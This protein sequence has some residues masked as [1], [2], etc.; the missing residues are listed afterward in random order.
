MA[1]VIVTGSEGFLGRNLVPKLAELGHRVIAID[2]IMHHGPHLA[3]VT[4][5]YFD[6][7][8]ASSLLPAMD[9][10]G[11]SVLIHLAWGLSRFKGFEGQAAQVRL[12]ACL[13]DFA[14]EKRF[15]KVVLMGSA[16]EF[17]RCSG[18]ISEA[19]APELP[20]SP[21]GWAKR[22]ARDLL[23]SWSA[24]SEIPAMIMR[25]FIMYGP[26]QR[27]DL[28]LPSAIE[29]AR[30]KKPT[31]FTD[32]QQVRDFVYVDD[33]SRAILAGLNKD[34][35][36][37]HEFNLGHGGV[38]VVDTLNMISRHFDAEEFIQVGARPRRPGEPDTQIADCARAKCQL[39][40]SAD[41]D[42]REGLKRCF[43]LFS[44]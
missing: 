13:L 29:A 32:G 41:I 5:E 38:K 37:F 40:W 8:K 34:L 7:S 4:Y 16:E 6:L 20:L 17:G 1:N 33:V 15:A 12:L 3:D 28:L 31:A 21:Y 36:G 9:I 39:G 24:R 23:L 30:N 10:S 14:L 18:T 42:W 19:T 35:P 26:G 44:K 27:G 25:P 43:Q 11:R 2:R 22:S